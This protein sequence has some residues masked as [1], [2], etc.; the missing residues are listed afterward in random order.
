MIAAILLALTAAAVEPVVILHDFP[1]RPA[2][3]Y[4]ICK[5]RMPVCVIVE[6]SEMICF[7]QPGLTESDDPEIIHCYTIIKDYS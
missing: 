2:W 4:A 3:I 7:S 1:A 5:N 6:S